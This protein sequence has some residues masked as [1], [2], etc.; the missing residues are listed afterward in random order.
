MKTVVYSF[1]LLFEGKPKYACMHE[2][3][4]AIRPVTSPTPRAVITVIRYFFE[5]FLLGL[6]PGEPPELLVLGVMPAATSW[7]CSASFALRYLNV[8]STNTQDN[9]HT[10]LRGTNS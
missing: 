3:I 5:T 1:A 4:Q 6:D 10:L 7:A 2:S 8:R 9:C